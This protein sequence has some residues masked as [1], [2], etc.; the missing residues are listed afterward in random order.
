MFKNQRG[1]FYGN[2]GLWMMLVCVLG[3]IIIPPIIQI[4]TYGLEERWARYTAPQPP[5]DFWEGFA[6]QGLN[7]LMA[8]AYLI[9]GCIVLMILFALIYWT[10]N[11]FWFE[12][13]ETNLKC[14]IFGHEYID[15]SHDQG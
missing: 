7:V 2:G 13:K 8:F 11:Y 5:I 9:G 4:A 1:T 3:V 6:T 10:L 15:R 14:R 12:R